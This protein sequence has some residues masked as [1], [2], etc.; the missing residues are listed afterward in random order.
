MPTELLSV[1]ETARQFPT[2]AG[3]VFFKLQRA[4]FDAA[5]RQWNLTYDV[6]VTSEKVKKVVIDD[7]SG[8]VVEFE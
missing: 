6:G 7:P 2:Q 5:K 4:D 8:K 1:T 3:Y